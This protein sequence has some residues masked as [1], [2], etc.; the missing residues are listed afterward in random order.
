MNI[1]TVVLFFI[2]GAAFGSFL[3]VVADRLISGQSLVN[4]PSHCPSCQRR[5]A[6]KDLI[7]IIS[8]IL[9][10]GRCRNC[11]S[12][13]PIRS[14]LVELFAAILFAL[15]VWHY[16]IT[17]ELVIVLVYCCLFIA[18]IIADIEKG[19]LPN[20]LVYSGMI[21][22]LGI[23]IIGTIFGYEPSFISDTNARLF[24]LWI[25]EAALG[26]VAGFI[27]L[28]IIALIFRGGMGWGDVKLAGFIGIATGYP[29]VF[30]AIFLA[31][32]AGGLISVALVLAKIRGRKETIPFGPFLAVAAIA[33]LVWGSQLLN[34]YLAASILPFAK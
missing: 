32:V 24:R 8:F 23:S 3:N 19:I 12:S 26:G 16:G 10:R 30:I 6:Y 25:L 4:P 33:T 34:W 7:P 17:W 5:I 2:L 28:F 27:I 22:A 15:L 20:R 21:I 9:L 13:I 11:G 18:L 31:V 1:L 29:L 14:V